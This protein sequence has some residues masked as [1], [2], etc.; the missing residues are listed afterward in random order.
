M[1]INFNDLPVTHL[2]HFNGGEGEL[3]AN[4]L[5]DERN[6]ILR[7]R[8]APGA[9]IGLHQHATSSEVIYVLEGKG[10]AITDGVEEML[11]AGDCHYCQKGQF[12]TLINDG[13]S[14]FVFFALVPQQ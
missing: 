2:V 11:L 14:D 6:K 12:H 5:V 10:K 3:Q 9:S 13:D 4:M 7:G 1:K 8:L